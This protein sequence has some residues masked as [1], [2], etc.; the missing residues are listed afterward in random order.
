MGLWTPNAPAVARS[1]G[2]MERNRCETRRSTSWPTLLRRQHIPFYSICDAVDRVVCEFFPFMPSFTGVSAICDDL[3]VTSDPPLALPNSEV[4]QRKFMESGRSLNL[5]K[6]RIL[7]HPDSAHLVVWPPRW[8]PGICTAIPIET[9]SAKQLGAP[10]GTELFRTDFVSRRV[11]KTTA[12]VAALERLPPSATWTLLRFCINERV[13]YLAQ[14]T[15]F[16]L[17]KDSLACMDTII[18]QALLHA[19]GLPP[20][21]SDPLTHLTTLTLCSLPTELGGLG[22]RRYSGLAGEIAYLLA[23]PYRVL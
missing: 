11:S 8:R 21:P 19:A 10:I 22:I 5:K 23:R 15:E 2:G 18:D 20:E 17:V 14:V 13:N 4:V 7:V 6:I 9:D 16:P 3:Q 12:L 1:A